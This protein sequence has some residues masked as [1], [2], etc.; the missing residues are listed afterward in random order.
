[1]PGIHSMN[2]TTITRNTLA[3]TAIAGSSND[4]GRND[5][6]RNY[7]GCEQFL[8]QIQRMPRPGLSRNRGLRSE[9]GGRVVR[10]DETQRQTW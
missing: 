10:G 8:G 9:C 2:L 7:N 5:I 4:N 6:G 1:M 3:Y